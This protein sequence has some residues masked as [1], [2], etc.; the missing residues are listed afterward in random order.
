MVNLL[1]HSLVHL[2]LVRERE[3]R[4]TGWTAKA[5]PSRNHVNSANRDLQTNGQPSEVLVVA[6]GGTQNAA[7]NTPW[8]E[9]RRRAYERIEIGVLNFSGGRLCRYTFVDV[10]L[11]RVRSVEETS[12]F[13]VDL[14]AGS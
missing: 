2:P 6:E 4:V 8:T 11:E 5:R 3:I 10:A 1:L 12:R 13:V 9:K 14:L 7:W